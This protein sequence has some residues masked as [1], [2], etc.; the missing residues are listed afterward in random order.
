MFIYLIIIKK[1]SE[2]VCSPM[3]NY[4]PYLKCG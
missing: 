1:L 3:G 2:K 4:M